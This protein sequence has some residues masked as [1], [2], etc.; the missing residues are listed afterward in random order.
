MAVFRFRMQNILNMKEKLE[1]QAKQD[2]AQA[3]KEY[4]DEVEQLEHLKKRKEDY[5]AYGVELR[6]KSIDIQELRDNKY[7]IERM[8]DYIK[9]QELAVTMAQKKMDAAMRKMMD[10]RTETKTY[11]KLREH[12]FEAFMIEEGKKESKEIDELNSYRF[13]RKGEDGVQA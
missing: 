11:E 3:Q 2:F 13:S 8:D 4:F 5:I 6:N 1:E 7:A 9:E 12:D 10:A